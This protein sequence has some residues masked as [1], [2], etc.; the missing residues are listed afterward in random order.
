MSNLYDQNSNLNLAKILVLFL[1]KKFLFLSIL[2]PFFVSSI[3][4]VYQIPG[5]FT[6]SGLVKIGRV[7]YID[8]AQN[9]TSENI[10]SGQT[11][12]RELAFYFPDKT[13]KFS[14]PHDVTNLL[15]IDAYGETYLESMNKIKKIEEFI[16]NFHKSFLKS[17]IERYEYELV[18][19]TNT[20]NDI[21]KN[22]EN[23][24]GAI[25][26]DTDIETYAKVTDRLTKLKFILNN[27]SA[28]DTKLVNKIIVE[29]SSVIAR[30]VIIL[31]SAIIFSIFLTF[32]ILF[33]QE[34]LKE[35]DS[36]TSQ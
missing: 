12:S 4:Y 22:K 8:H 10:S 27:P 26:Q 1:E 33:I 11:L 25:I 21:K 17:S 31:V 18:E 35:K 32:L 14:Y 2:L 19:V 15:Q 5:E 28:E 34:I 29:E 23:T 9:I 30:K 3:Y 6:S 36:Q 20:L 7:N 13:I 24:G 16:V